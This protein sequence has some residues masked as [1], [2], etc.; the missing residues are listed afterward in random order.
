MSS[1]SLEERLR[2]GGTGDAG[3][4]GI[5]G[6]AS[7]RF[8]GVRGCRASRESCDGVEA[9][10]SSRAHAPGG[11]ACAARP[12]TVM[13]LE[14]AGVAD[15]RAGPG[16]ASGCWPSA[17][18]NGGS[19]RRF[20]AR[21]LGVEAATELPPHWAPLL[22]AVTLDAAGTVGPVSPLLLSDG[23]GLSAASTTK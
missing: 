6:C 17:S 1:C 22:S 11:D 10:L 15:S 5:G 23:E 20:N 9:E 16:E 3:P 14:V 12:S 18:R 8:P 7:L 4:V 19:S 21:W 2:R 13:N